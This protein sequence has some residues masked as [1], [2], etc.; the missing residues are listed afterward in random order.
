MFFIFQKQELLS[1]H[2]WFASLKPYWIPPRKTLY[3][4]PSRPAV[5]SLDNQLS[6]SFSFFSLL[7]SLDCTVTVFL[8]ISLYYFLFFLMKKYLL[9]S[10]FNFFY[11]LKSLHWSTFYFLQIFFCCMNSHTVSI[12]RLQSLK[13]VFSWTDNLAVICIN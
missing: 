11:P 6:I 13:P 10:L 1:E 7:V 2:E 12:Q 3:N 4:R 5:L 8:L 9:C